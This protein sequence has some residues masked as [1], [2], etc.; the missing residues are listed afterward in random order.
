MR[1]LVLLLTL[2][3]TLAAPHLPA[4][5]G[6]DAAMSPPAAMAEAMDALRSGDWTGAKQMG[7]AAGPVGRDVID[8]HWLRS[9]LGTFDDAVDFLE[10][11]G[12]WPGLPYLKERSEFDLPLSGRAKDVLFFFGDDQP[13]TGHGA[14]ALTRAYAELGQEPDAEA[15][16][17]L[18]WLNL[19]MTAEAE[20][21]LLAMY[22]DLLAPLEAA[23]LDMA[24][25]NGWSNAAG[26]AA[27]RVDDAGLK[28]LA[29]AR[30]ALRAEAGNIDALIEAVP[31]ALA[32]DPGLAYERFRWRLAKGLREEAIELL[33]D[34]SASPE[35]LGRPEPWARAGAT[36]RA[37]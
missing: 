11:R 14:V 18:S 1:H 16:A 21:Q 26:R 6:G 37:N 36:L 29:E 10:R 15:Q 32:D 35:R 2:V 23:R 3:A 8:W 12:D 30:M 13:D 20:S 28:A 5:Q 17:V 31:E 19:S 24:L 34:R 4:A 22:P 9:G 25:W 27:T 33:I 7:D